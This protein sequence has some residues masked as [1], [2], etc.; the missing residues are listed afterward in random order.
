MSSLLL[1]ALALAFVAAPAIAACADKPVRPSEVGC[2][3]THVEGQ[4]EVTLTLNPR[5]AEIPTE[6]ANLLVRW[7]WLQPQVSGEVPDRLTT[8]HLTWSE[9][10]SRAANISERASKSRCVVEVGKGSPRCDA[11]RAI[12]YVE[13]EP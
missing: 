7:E 9:A 12:I 2:E 11:L 5:E 8:Y 1:K 10:A 4:C 13:A 6:A 3:W